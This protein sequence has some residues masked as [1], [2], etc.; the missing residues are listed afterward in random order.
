MTLD[1]SYSR[2]EAYRK[3]ARSYQ[4]SYINGLR[5]IGSSATPQ[6][7]GDLFHQLMEKA[8]MLIYEYQTMGDYP[9]YSALRNHV[10]EYAGAWID[11]RRGTRVAAE[12]GLNVLDQWDDVAA[13]AVS[14]VLRTLDYLDM[15]NNYKIAT[16]NGEPLIEYNLEYFEPNT[17][18]RFLGRI[19][20]VLF[21]IHTHA[22]LVIDWKFTGSFKTEEN[23]MLNSQLALYSYILMRLGLDTPLGVLYQVRNR[24]PDIP[25]LN[26][27]QKGKTRT[28][29]RQITTD[30]ETYRTF[31][32]ENNLDPADYED[33]RH[34]LTE[35]EYWKPIVVYRNEVTLGIIWDNF[36]KK[37]LE[38]YAP[39]EY[40]AD[41]GYQCRFCS[42]ATWCSTHL[43]GRD[44][45]EL[46]GIV[47][48]KKEFVDEIIQAE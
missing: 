18:I 23:E 17:A 3:C 12:Y 31:I 42:F 6:V 8:M 44:P 43:E 22:H 1:T 24:P 28:V 41:Y 25:R 13:N 36:I 15:P 19:D 40:T 46:I 35:I 5:T 4:L 34:K 27:E 48:T 38:M 2:V 9:S 10:N 33:M 45:Q 37:T 47:Y 26:K 30:W 29:S 39:Q 14:V 7:Q 21:D 20:L 16:L 32:V 11:E